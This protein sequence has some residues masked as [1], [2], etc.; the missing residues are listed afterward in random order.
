MLNQ[1]IAD[2]TKM[3][4]RIIGEDIDLQCRY[5]EPLPFVQADAGMIEQVLLNLAVNARDAM[6]RGGQLAITHGRA[7]LRRRVCPN[8]PGSAGRVSLSA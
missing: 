2:L 6:P 4:K 5:A 1:V 3:L 8:P 7:R